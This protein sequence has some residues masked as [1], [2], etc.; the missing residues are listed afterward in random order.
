MQWERFTMI[1]DDDIYK[2]IEGKDAK[3]IYDIGSNNGDDI[4]YYLMKGDKVIAVEANPSLAKQIE[5][6][7]RSEIISGKLIVENCVVTVDDPGQVHFYLHKTNHLVSQLPEPAPQEL[8]NFIKVELPS[9]NIIDIIKKYGQPYYIKIDIE[10]Y[11]QYLLKCLFIND[12]RPPYLSCES[13]SI[14]IFCILVALGNYSSFKLVDGATISTKYASH[15]IGVNNEMVP[16]SFPYHSAGPMGNDIMGKWMNRANFF[17]VLAYAKLGWKDIHVSKV[18]PPDNS[19]A[20]QPLF[21]VVI[22]Y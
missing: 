17:T 15:G 18:D 14:D 3:I 12:V 19:Y 22:K 7:F 2:F 5:N 1:P 21:S 8:G 4:P 20:P 10:H 6:R 9:K 13:H 16:Y 11:D